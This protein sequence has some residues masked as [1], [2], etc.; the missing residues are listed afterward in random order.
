MRQN[1]LR[2]GFT[3]GTGSFL[4]GGSAPPRSSYFT[5]PSLG[6]YQIPNQVRHYD[7]YKGPGGEIVRFDQLPPNALQQ[8]YRSIGSYGPDRPRRP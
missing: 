2:M 5:Q 8:G 7:Y 4:G 3:G 1:S 6:T